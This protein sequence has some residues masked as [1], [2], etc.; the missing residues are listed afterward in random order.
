MTHIERI[1]ERMNKE[2][3]E[4]IFVSSAINQFY[5]GGFDYTDGYVLVLPDKG[6]L[7]ADFRYIEAAK[8]AIVESGLGEF[9]EVVMPDTSM[10]RYVA[11]LLEKHGVKTVLYEERELTC[12]VRDRVEEIFGAVGV[13]V[14]S[15]ASAIFADTRRVKDADEIAKICRAQALTDAAFEHILGYINPDRTE[16]DVALELEFFMRAHGSQGTAFETIAVSG[17]ASSRPHGVP[18]PVKLEKGFLTMDFGARVDGY[19]SDMTRTVVIGKADDE[20]K[21]L[22]NT[23]LEA[24]TTAISSLYEGMTCSD[25]DKVARDIID[26]AG[27]KGYFGHSLGHGVGLFIHEEPR[28]AATAGEELERGHVVTVEPGIYI[29]GKYGCRIE[30]MIAVQD[31]GSIIDL[32]HSPKELIELC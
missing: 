27:Y 2:G 3:A 1:W 24:Q 20:M 6:Y 22:Y 9:I 12:A 13:E 23:V 31:D 28:F 29:E 25:A 11:G 15:G 30:D 4:A 26:N 7:L 14:K 32:T 19:C 5:V 8:A 16:L 10:L 21:R 17:S 18:R